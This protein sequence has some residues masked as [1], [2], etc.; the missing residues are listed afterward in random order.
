[1]SNYYFK[2]LKYKKKYMDLKGGSTKKEE[3]TESA[4]KKKAELDATLEND[5]KIHTEKVN[6]LRE[7]STIIGAEKDASNNRDLDFE[8]KKK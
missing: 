1:M 6:E 4:K 5:A 2:Y 8:K 3:L 7:T